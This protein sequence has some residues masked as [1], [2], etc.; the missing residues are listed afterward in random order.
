MSKASGSCPKVELAAEDG[1]LT[2]W[3]LPALITSPGTSRLKAPV[4][5]RRSSGTRI[6]LPQHSTE[7]VEEI[8]I[9]AVSTF[10]NY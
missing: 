3:L 10:I 1:E 2:N 4:N 7:S 6:T 8:K 5:S 9:K